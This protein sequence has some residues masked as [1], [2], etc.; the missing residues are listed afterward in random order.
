V[1]L[2]AEQLCLGQTAQY[3]A[4]R[5]CGWEVLTGPGAGRS[6]AAGSVCVWKRPGVRV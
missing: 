3:G 1:V 6:S 2:E 4:K 5:T